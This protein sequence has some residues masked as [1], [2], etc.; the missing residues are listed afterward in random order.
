MTRGRA[1]NLA[2]P[3]TKALAQQRDYRARKAANIARLEQ[4][5]EQLRKE[6]SQLTKE[7]DDVRNGRGHGVDGQPRSSIS[8]TSSAPSSEVNARMLAEYQHLRANY[9][10]LEAEVRRKEHVL[11]SLRDKERE[12]FVRLEGL[13][14]QSF[15][16]VGSGL[17]AQDGIVGAV[18]RGPASIKEE[19]LQRILDPSLVPRSG[20][21]GLSNQNAMQ[22]PS[23]LPNGHSAGPQDRR[24]LTDAPYA[25][26]VQSSETT[27]HGETSLSPDTGSWR[28]RKRLRS[29]SVTLDPTNH[30]QQPLAHQPSPNGIPLPPRDL[31]YGQPIS[32]PGPYMS[33]GPG[34][35][36]E[37]PNSIR[38]TSFTHLRPIATRHPDPNL[39]RY[40]LENG[41]SP[42]HSLPAFNSPRLEV[43]SGRRFTQPSL[44]TTTPPPSGHF[45]VSSEKSA[46]LA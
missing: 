16:V 13:L 18:P 46:C 31:A 28:S 15:D 30:P 20:S 29:S 22:R 4:E 14:K 33:A 6:N 24:F 25:Q 27:V 2:L 41:S 42:T 11:Q 26:R 34:D 5:N 21:Y 19:P 12:A 8:T 44:S 10:A 40:P 7:L 36:G 23:S 45:R 1:P 43:A 3:L 37:Y 39:H 17:G 38:R 9:D 32:Y 35:L